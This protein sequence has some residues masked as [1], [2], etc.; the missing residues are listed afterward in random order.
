[1]EDI[2]KLTKR[3]SAPCTCDR[4]KAVKEF[5]DKVRTGEIKT[6]SFDINK[7]SLKLTGK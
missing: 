7:E 2:D 6:E 1:M 4:S 3:M 5:I